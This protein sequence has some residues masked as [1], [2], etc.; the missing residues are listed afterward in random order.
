MRDAHAE[1]YDFIKVYNR[2][3]LAPFTASVDEARTLHMRVAGRIPA[4]V[5]AHAEEYAQQTDPP[6]LAAIPRYVEMA[7][8]H[9]IWLVATLTLDER[10]LDETTHRMPPATALTLC[11]R[12][13]RP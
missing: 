9:G 6:D 1:G 8:S 3:R 13:S 5:V 7:R 4:C 10:T 2:L 12:S 11:T